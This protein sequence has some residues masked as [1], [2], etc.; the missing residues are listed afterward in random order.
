MKLWQ[1]PLKALSAL[2]DRAFAVIGAALFSQAPAF[3]THYQQRLGGHVDE[4]ARNVRTWQEIADAIAQGSLDTLVR[5]G[6]AS[7]EAFSLEAARKCAEDIARH[8]ALLHAIEA[9]Q[10]APAW[11]RSAVFL[12]HADM[13]VARATARNFT[14]NLPMDFEGLIYALVG[15]IFGFALFSLLKK[16]GAGMGRVLHKRFAR[17]N[18]SSTTTE[19]R[20]P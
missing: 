5:M 11:L 8:D 12:H 4:A 2:I 14:P 1:H 18:T 19:P 13:D 9:V 3:V 7:H 6:Q 20:K 15:L 16:A 10:N 17:S